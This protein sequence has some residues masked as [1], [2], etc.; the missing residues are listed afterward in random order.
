MSH[1]HLCASC[2]RFRDII[3]NILPS[4]SM[5]R[6]RR[7]KTVL[8]PSIRKCWNVYCCI[9]FIILASGNIRKR[10]NLTNV[11]IWNRKC[12]SRSRNRKTG[13]TPID[14]KCLNVYYR[15]F[16]FLIFTEVRPL[17][18]KVTDTP[19]HTETDKFIAIGEI[20]QICL[21]ILLIGGETHE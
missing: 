2:Y 1:T 12:R 17:R 5:S 6:S 7:W 9:F 15:F 20:L 11:Y 14:F 13:L 19:R 16:I 10:M 4:K 8:K 21:Q 18:K 3:I